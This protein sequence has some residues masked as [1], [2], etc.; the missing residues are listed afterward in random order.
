MDEYLPL[1]LAGGSTRLQST[2]MSDQHNLPE[3]KVLAALHTEGLQDSSLLEQL[4]RKPRRCAEV[5]ATACGH[6]EL[7]LLAWQRVSGHQEVAHMN[8]LQRRLC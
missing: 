5:V 2:Q 8:A 1:V 6:H 4:A 3:L 7:C